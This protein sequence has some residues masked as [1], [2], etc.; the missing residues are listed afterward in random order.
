CK[1]SINRNAYISPKFHKI[2]IKDS[3]KLEQNKNLYVILANASGEE[4]DYKD[5]ARINKYLLQSNVPIENI[6]SLHGKRGNMTDLFKYVTK[7]NLERTVNDLSKKIT[8]KDKLLFY[9]TGHGVR[10][11]E[12]SYIS[13]WNGN[14]SVEDFEKVMQKLPE[15]DFA[16]FLFTQ[17]FSEPFAKK[18]GKGNKIG[19]SNANGES[20]GIINVGPEF[21]QYIFPKI[22]NK[23]VTIQKAFDIAVKKENCLLNKVSYWL[24]KSFGEVPPLDTP[25][26]CW[27]DVSPSELCLIE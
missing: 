9:L 2:M 15:M 25:Q 11:N 18:M 23:K 17:C 27:Q 19:I 22:L 4:E 6:Y 13:C 5:V 1:V 3:T 26:L 16:V 24:S 21:S 8:K 12:Q 14:L 20:R 7:N 10:K